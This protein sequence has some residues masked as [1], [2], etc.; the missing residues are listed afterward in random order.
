MLTSLIVHS[1]N[2]KK[3]MGRK[4]K[5]T[6]S[7]ETI[8]DA[9]VTLTDKIGLGALTMRKLAAALGTAPMTIYY[10]VPAKEQLIELMVDRVFEEIEAPPPEEKWKE[11]I[12]KRCISA[13]RVLNRHS[14]AAPL[15]ESRGSPGPANLAHHEAVFRSFRT[16][17]FSVSLAA[18]A[19]AVLDS[20]VFGFAF[21]EATLP[22]LAEDTFTPIVS[23]IAEQLDG[24]GYPYLAEVAR[25][26]VLKPG[27]DF[28]ASFEFGLDMLLDGLERALQA[29]SI[30]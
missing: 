14:W 15:M 29:S 13:R 10:H 20:Y 7:R 23:G 17:G 11:A 18:H 5:T 19:Y 6:L 24:G 27:Y 30:R 26:H 3:N 9:A 4:E 1:T 21:E 28:G 25:D 22:G 8:V 16:A 12:R 2:V